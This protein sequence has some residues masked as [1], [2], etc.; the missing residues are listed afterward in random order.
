MNVEKLA[1]ALDKSAIEASIV[2]NNA[3]KFKY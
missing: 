1:I 2:Y 3:E